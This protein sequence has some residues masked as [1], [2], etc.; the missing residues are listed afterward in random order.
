MN[1]PSMTVVKYIPSC[2]TITSK[3]SISTTF[4]ATRK[5]IPIGEIL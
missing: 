4:A 5:N 1:N 2:P 3:L